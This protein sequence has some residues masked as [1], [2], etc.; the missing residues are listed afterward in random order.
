MAS[1]RSSS[2]FLF[3]ISRWDG[4]SLWVRFS[5]RSNCLLCRKGAMNLLEYTWKSTVLRC[6]LQ[7]KMQERTLI[8][9]PETR[10]TQ[11]DISDRFELVRVAVENRRQVSCSSGITAIDNNW[12]FVFM[13]EVRE[14]T[15]NDAKA[16]GGVSGHTSTMEVILRRV[17]NAISL[18]GYVC[19]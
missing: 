6:H 4:V 16:N 15:R 14:R 3:H 9:H 11:T 1:S 5:R 18:L 19:V 13:L 7:V 8:I 2:I 10:I 12:H 17:I